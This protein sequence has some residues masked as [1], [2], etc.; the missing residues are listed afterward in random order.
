MPRRRRHLRSKPVMQQSGPGYVN[1]ATLSGH[2]VSPLV[3]NGE[4]GSIVQVP[5]TDLRARTFRG[6]EAV[7]AA[8]AWIKQQPTNQPWMASRGF[9]NGT[10]AGDATSKSIAAFIGSGHQQSR[11]L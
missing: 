5:S 1:F 7:D 4:D 9:R 8:I 6:T 2:Y 3:I 10:Y 11:L